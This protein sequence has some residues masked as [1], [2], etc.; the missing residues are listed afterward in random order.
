MTNPHGEADSRLSRAMMEK[1]SRIEL[2][3]DGTLE[4]R[5]CAVRLT[6]GQT[7]ERVIFA[8]A[9][10][11]YREWGVWP[12]EDRDKVAI[13]PSTVVDIW[14]SPVRM[15]A[16]LADAL[17]RHG[18]SG[19]GFYRVTIRFRDNSA[20]RFTAGNVVDFPYLPPGATGESIVSVDYDEPPGPIYEAP[21]FVWCL[22]AVSG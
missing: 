18:E 20:A 6:D 9:D 12:D 13:S 8:E 15:P 16:H 10:S 3:H 22:Y 2:S 11:W 19:M 7:V 5:P 1:L 4:Y 14:E 21:P 17:Y